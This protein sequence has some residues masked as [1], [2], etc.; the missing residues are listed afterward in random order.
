M[1]SQGGGLWLAVSMT[2]A[3]APFERT[4]KESAGVGVGSAAKRTSSPTEVSTSLTWRAKRPAA[5]RVS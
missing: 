3:A 1:P 5:K 4:A 2:P